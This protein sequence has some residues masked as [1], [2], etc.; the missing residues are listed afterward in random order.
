MSIDGS[1]NATSQF[2]S[3]FVSIRVSSSDDDDD[4]GDNG[5]LEGLEDSECT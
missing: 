3:S 1:L 2:S 5:I 4:F